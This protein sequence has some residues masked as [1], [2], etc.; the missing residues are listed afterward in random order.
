MEYKE[1]E[2]LILSELNLERMKQDGEVL[3]TLQRYSGS[4]DGEKSVDYIL[5]ELEKVGV[6]QKRLRHE[7]FRSL[8]V[9]ASVTVAGEEEPIGAIA[10]VYSGEADQLTGELIWDE[11]CLMESLT[12]NDWEARFSNVKGKI[13]LTYDISFPFY[14]EAARA[15]ALGV[16]AI[17]PK[18]ILHHDTMGGVWG[19]PGSRDRDLYPY[20]PYVQ[21]LDAD[22]K[23]LMKKISEGTVIVSMNIK[24]DTGIVK[25][26]M[27]MATIKGKSDKFV[28]L[29]GH[30][31]S[32]YEGMTDNGAANILM[33]E[34]AR[35]LK[36]HQDELERSVVVVWWSGHSDGRYS[37]SSWFCD[38]YYEYL[39]DN[40]VAHINMDIC[41]CMG[42]NA[43]RL[44]MTGMEGNAFND[45]F[46]APYNERKPLHYRALN[47]SS[48]QTFWGVLTPVAVAPQFYIDDVTK[49]QAVMPESILKELPVPAAFGE[50]GPFFWWHT[51]YDTLDKVSDTVLLRDC[52][53]AA[54]LVCRYAMMKPLPVDMN[55]FMEEMQ[56]YFQ[57]FARELD[58]DFDVKPVLPVIE[59]TKAAVAN[60][61]AILD[62][63]P[64]K[65]ADD[66]L[67]QAAGE[68]VRLKFTYSSPYKHDYAVEHLPYGV[69]SS[70]LGVHA[71]NTPPLRYLMSQTDFVRQRNRMIYQLQAVC[72]AIELQMYRWNQQ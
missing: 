32:W 63:D 23:R 11:Y 35:V 24:M 40:C 14:Y 51:I 3:G 59:K 37:G 33:L 8:P 62:E 70:L 9:C 42:S 28:L 26:S 16:I 50:G 15:G 38:H 45:E 61:V 49:T 6:C 66:I 36:Q 54:R 44:D 4:A 30:Y 53:I 48:D 57:A 5:S 19:M 41:G 46:L 34:T 18:D 68:L 20:L 12:G 72:D 69:F 17:W 47:R 10:A 7:M 43:V 64:Q 22:G 52:E 21:I 27:P 29:S 1:F 13:L 60:L 31:D 65:D 55:G 39:R 56:E 58:G 25:C 2:K 67:I 71:D